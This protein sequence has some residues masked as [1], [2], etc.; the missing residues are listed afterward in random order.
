MAGELFVL[1]PLRLLHAAEAGD[2][3]ILIAAH[4]LDAALHGVAALLV[5]AAADQVQQLFLLAVHVLGQ[6]QTAPRDGG[7]QHLRHQRAHLPQQGLPAGEIGRLRKACEKAEALYLA[8]AADHRLDRGAVELVQAGGKLLH[9]RI[10]RGA[11]AQN[12][13]DQR[14]HGR[15]LPPQLREKIDAHAGGL[16]FIGSQMAQ[17]YA[18]HQLRP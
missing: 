14:V 18:R 1:D 17:K 6:Q 9:I 3:K 2:G 8:Y 15:G 7:Q 4:L 13:G 5:D 16:E 11:A 12:G 10:A